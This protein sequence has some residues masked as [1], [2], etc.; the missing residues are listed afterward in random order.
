MRDQAAH[1]ERRARTGVTEAL[2]RRSLRRRLA[3]VTLVV[4]LYSSNA[5]GA[6]LLDD[7]DSGAITLTGPDGFSSTPADV[8]GGKRDLF[9]QDNDPPSSTVFGSFSLAPTNDYLAFTAGNS[10]GSYS[11]DYS[12]IDGN[13]APLDLDLTADGADRLILNLSR[14][15]A[16]GMLYARLTHCG[17]FDPLCN[18]SGP[19]AQDAF[20][21]VNLGGPGSYAFPFASF[22]P[23]LD[24][25]DVDRIE[26]GFTGGIPPFST[27]QFRDLSTNGGTPP[28]DRFTGIIDDFGHGDLDLPGLISSVSVP[29]DVPGGYRGVIVHDSTPP[30]ATPSRASLVDGSGV[31]DIAVGQTP[32]NYS[33]TY[34]RQPDVVPLD[35]DFESAGADRFVVE[36]DAAP[37]AGVIAIFVTTCG[38]GPCEGS[39]FTIDSSQPLTGPGDYEF[40]FASFGHPFVDFGNIDAIE[41]NFSSGVPPQAAIRIDTF[42]TNLGAT[43]VPALSGPAAMALGLLLGVV[44]TASLAWSRRAR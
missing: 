7:F 29:A 5:N 32:G 20:A 21:F 23:P 19:G 35:I 26:V 30:G 13:I 31:L 10:P 41:I 27:L 12:G 33:V 25:T 22:S 44:G 18:P 16:G 24:F 40:P 42:R 36:L 3:E 11:I 34:G 43:A 9:I 17:D 1:R 2:P 39:G 15:P 38:V 8:P 28:A 6:R 37:T 4:A 14:A